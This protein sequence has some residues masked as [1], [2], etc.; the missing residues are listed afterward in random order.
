MASTL[1]V[2]AQ[3]ANEILLEIDPTNLSTVTITSTG[4]HS[5][6]NDS[7]ADGTAGIWLQ[8]VFSTGGV[9]SAPTSS[10][11]TPAGNTGP[12][13]QIY[14]DFFGIDV[15]DLG[16]YRNSSEVQNF[17]TT[18]P[19]F[20]GSM[21]AD[22]STSTFLSSSVGTTG[23][24]RV[25]DTTTGSNALIGYYKIVPEPTSLSILAGAGL[26]IARRRRGCLHQPA[27]DRDI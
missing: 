17:Q 16:F 21:T 23:E 8:G 2:S 14:N 6:I 22:F 1:S 15:T 26:L 12:Y 11:L 18:A 13:D 25:G 20:T 4:N 5:L 7:S 19:A 9:A 24:I 3:S 10:T 27:A